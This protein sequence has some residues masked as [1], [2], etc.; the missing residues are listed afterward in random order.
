MGVSA[1]KKERN[2]EAAASP[3]SAKFTHV[4]LDILRKSFKDLAQRSKGNTMDKETFL[5]FFPLPGLHGERLFHVFD[6]KHTGVIDFDEFINGLAVCVRGSF[7]EKVR[8]IFSIYDID[9]NELVSK[10]ELG[11]MLHQIPRDALYV[12]S[13][14]LEDH[15]DLRSKLLVENQLE[16]PTAP[17]TSA[18]A[19]AA[20][21]SQEEV[22][23]MALDAEAVQAEAAAQEDADAGF[24]A[25][26]SPRIR[27]TSSASMVRRAQTQAETSAAA[28]QVVDHLVEDAFKTF[29]L[30]KDDKL[31]PDQFREWVKSTPEVLEFVES[32]FPFQD[33][34]A[35]P[36][37]S[38]A[39]A[40]SSAATAGQPRTR[41][42]G[43]FRRRRL[44][45][46]ASLSSLPLFS[47]GS[48][49]PSPKSPRK[50]GS[51]SSRSRTLRQRL[52]SSARGMQ[53][54]GAQA[55]CAVSGTIGDES[56]NGSDDEAASVPGSVRSHSEM[57]LS[58]AGPAE[59][60]T[61]LSFRGT[62]YK[63]GR[64]TKTIRARYFVLQGSVLYY[65]YPNKLQ[66]PAGIIFLQGCFVT[67]RNEDTVEA[68]RNLRS[69]FSEVK[70]LKKRNRGAETEVT[71]GGHHHSA[72][73][74]MYAFEVITSQGGERDSRIFYAKTQLQRSEW[75]GF[76]KKASRVVPFSEKYKRLERLG[77]GKFAVVYKCELR[78]SN[79]GKAKE[80][81]IY[82]AVKVI[83][84]AQ[85]N[86]R[87]RELLRTEI[88]VL[89]LVHHPNIISMQ[90]VFESLNHI[91]IVLEFVQG[92]ELFDRIVGRARL[93]EEETYPLIKQLS[94]A[95]YY[96]HCLGVAHR[97][98]KPEN[99]LCSGS[100]D[101]PLAKATLKICDFGL[102][103]LISPQGVMKLACGTLSYV[104]PEVL[105]SEG[106]GKA[107]D[108]WNIGVIVYLVRRGRLP[109][110]GETKD[111]VIYNTVHTRLDFERDSVFS[112]SSRAFIS[113]MKGLLNK[114][115]SRRLSARQIL[116]HPWMLKM[117]ERF[118]GDPVLGPLPPPQPLPLA[119]PTRPRTYAAA[120]ARPPLS[121]PT[122]QAAPP[123]VHPLVIPPV[124]AVLES[125][126]NHRQVD[127]ALR[128]LAREDI[129]KEQVAT[130]PAVAPVGAPNHERRTSS[131]YSAD[132][133]VIDHKHEASDIL[134]DQQQQQQQP[135]QVD[136][137]GETTEQ[138]A[139][140]GEMD[141][142]DDEEDGEDQ[143]QDVGGEESSLDDDA[144]PVMRSASAGVPR[145][146]K[147]HDDDDDDDDGG[148]EE[149]TDH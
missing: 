79:E 98:I 86:E 104:A 5:K 27:H 78:D 111:D 43:S 54:S 67:V 142:E 38:V 63:V 21:A 46:P 108:I 96:L 69:Q 147:L 145:S 30:N 110:D 32:V 148:D 95:V 125:S 130:A 87:E 137:A 114:D 48:A 58:S 45:R 20:M 2:G 9:N 128:H 85:L 117:A 40:P 74:H 136:V 12:L 70:L 8:V 66:Q 82:F 102:S 28:M 29:D 11:T 60:N 121:P 37:S 4:E 141:D 35:S 13:G 91:Y 52:S 49:V 90:D 124:D 17:P 89:K 138:E 94:Q 131:D 107:A 68:V 42:S 76:I 41:L 55:A 33:T 6:H 146:V 103:K 75:I 139:G 10:E 1:S 149:G 115:P 113:L 62:L 18:H 144:E 64:R 36:D 112:K 140:E 116:E 81:R 88:A 31:S 61:K 53:G 120:A 132:A 22:A 71:G 23:A 119:A 133:V 84:K 92:G 39:S 47:L 19:A 51:G 123:V 97:D 73:S 26:E 44:D 106:Y 101:D 65:Y 126:E 83:D 72:T 127:Q 122:V 59:D 50:H 105:T 24:D 135:T 109:F 99:I 7:D 118:P 15:D 57:S 80:D 134:H 56:T 93:T 143:D 16:P 25:G 3:A 14:T 100:K 34:A 129:E 77:Q